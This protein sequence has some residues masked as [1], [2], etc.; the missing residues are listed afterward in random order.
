MT[1]KIVLPTAE[2]FMGGYIPTYAAI[3]GVFLGNS[4]G[5]NVEVGQANFKE[6]TTVGD[7]RA[8]RITPKDNVIKQVNAKED[9]FSFKKY[10]FANQYLTS[11]LQGSEGAADVAAMVLDEHHVQA[12]DLLLN[13]DGTSSADI[14]NDGLLISKSSKYVLE[15]Q[16]TVALSDQLHKFFT[17][18]MTTAAKANNI[19]GQKVLFLYGT[20]TKALYNSLFPNS[21]QPVKEVLM[22]SLGANYAIVEIPDAPQSNKATI[23][24]GW[25]IA[26][27]TQTKLH[28][29]KL[30]SLFS[31][32]VNDEKMH[33]WMNFLMGSMALELKASGAII[34]QP[35]VIAAS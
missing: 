32:G 3:Y 11:S 25:V 27:L 10:F 26:N 12:D 14:L 23:D 8:K 19:S 35:A 9:V 24:E 33:I 5:H 16:A 20:K 18:I 7:I 6:M 22:K 21:D 31:Q 34:H 28:Y 29:V 17:A 1:N 4:F 13:G 15:S 30:P 2:E